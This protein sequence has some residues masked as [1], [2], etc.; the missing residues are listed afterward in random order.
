MAATYAIAARTSTEL[1][2]YESSLP[3]RALCAIRYWPFHNEA[4]GN[5]SYLTTLGR[6]SVNA[7]SHFYG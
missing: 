5:V 2:W 1:S 7:R 6:A 3:E 4:A